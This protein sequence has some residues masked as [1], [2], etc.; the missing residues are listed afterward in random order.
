MVAKKQVAGNEGKGEDLP[1][2]PTQPGNRRLGKVLCKKP[3]KIISLLSMCID[4]G[5]QTTASIILSD[6][7]VDFDTVL[8][9]ITKRRNFLAEDFEFDKDPLLCSLTKLMSSMMKVL[10][11]D[12]RLYIRDSFWAVSTVVGRSIL[13]SFVSNLNVIAGQAKEDAR[14]KKHIRNGEMKVEKA[15]TM[16]HD[17]F[18]EIELVLME[19]E[20]GQLVLGI[21]SMCISIVSGARDAAHGGGGVTAEEQ[22]WSEQ[23]LGGGSNETAGADDEADSVSKS[24]YGGAVQRRAAVSSILVSVESIHRAGNFVGGGRGFGRISGKASKDLIDS[25]ADLLRTICPL[26][27]CLSKA[28]E[29]LDDV[30]K[31]ISHEEAA[32]DVSSALET[33]TSKD[34][35]RFFSAAIAQN[36]KIKNAVNARRFTFAQVLEEAEVST[37]PEHW[38][39]GHKAYKRMFPSAVSVT[40]TGIVNRMIKYVNAHNFDQDETHCIRVFSALTAHLLR[41]RANPDGTLMSITE[42]LEG[43]AMQEKLGAFRQRQNHL[44][45]HGVTQAALF[46]IATHDSGSPG[47]LAD[48]ASTFLMEVVRY[49]N[50]KTQGTV[51]I[52]LK[53]MDKDAKIL[54]YLRTRLDTGRSAIIERQA[55]GGGIGFQMMEEAMHTE[56]S[57]LGRAL[58]LVT[59]F[60][61]GHNESFQNILR[62]QPER[63]F[64]ID[65]ISH[66]VDI[67]VLQAASNHALARMENADVDLLTQIMEV[68]VEAMQGPCTEN[69]K[70]ITSH[71]VFFTSVDRVMHTSFHE[72]VF[73]ST[74]LR[75]NAVA[76]DLLSACL[77]GRTDTLVH[78]IIALEMLPL[79]LDNARH[80]LCSL[81]SAAAQGALPK[82]DIE[83]TMQLSIRG[84][85][86]LT[87]VYDKM[88][89]V[90][91]FFDQLQ[92]LTAERRKAHGLDAMDTEVGQVE[93]NWNGVIEVVSFRNPPECVFLSAATKSKFEDKVDLRTAG[94]RTAA[95]F[96]K[97]PAFIFEMR[98]AAFMCENYSSYKQLYP[99]VGQFRWFVYALTVLLNFNL[100]MSTVGNGKGDKF[101]EQ[102][103][104]G[105]NRLSNVFTAALCLGVLIG[106]C[107]LFCFFSASEIPLLVHKTES[108]T[109]KLIANP[110]FKKSMFRD[111][112]AFSAWIVV[113]VGVAFFVFMHFQNYNPSNYDDQ[114]R[115]SALNLELYQ[116]LVLFCVIFYYLRCFRNWIVVPDT[117]ATRCYVILY[118]LLFRR[119]FFPRYT[120]LIVFTI[121]GYSRPEYCTL[122]LL[123]ILDLE[124]LLGAVVRCVIIPGRSLLLVIYLVLCSG[125]VYALFGI[126]NFENADWGDC[127]SAVSCFWLIVYKHVIKPHE[128]MG[129]AD[130]SHRGLNGE[131]IF[132]I[133]MLFDL[134]WFIWLFLL[135]KLLTALLY[136]TFTKLNA[137][138]KQRK[139]VL[140]NTGFVSGLG[141][142]PYG[143]LGIM[144]PS[145]DE[146]VKG[147]Q[148]HWNYVN[149]LLHLIKKNS[150]DYNGCESFVQKNLDEGSLEWLPIKTSFAIQE[151]AKSGHDTS[152]LK[153]GGVLT[154]ESTLAAFRKDFVLLNK[155]VKK[156]NRGM[157]KMVDAAIGKADKEKE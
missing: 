128:I 155:D 113:V 131:P 48:V 45:S 140:G 35:F 5:N 1:V 141:R 62:N 21:I 112:S 36:E 149:F 39:G 9:A 88:R 127:H 31:I 34:M 133:R 49:G 91:S 134:S 146:L 68:L 58:S 114:K 24:V 52:Y 125:A 111:S 4:H 27:A 98:Q 104:I 147:K 69:Q 8:F 18:Q 23:L 44:N 70:S 6:M 22:K 122:L 60:M 67:F 26:S 152:A 126:R 28:D 96:D 50:V 103:D 109:K 157:S 154:I 10:I 107:I 144:N 89:A 142:G 71:A 82:E 15:E 156:L 108:R 46:A 37:D 136:G 73:A 93:V 2:A 99:Y 135:F 57:H 51:L 83:E 94:K 143:D 42:D 124:F 80:Q 123:E 119:S 32:V 85:V 101:R 29:R 64:S 75:A 20:Q 117:R 41:A 132:M 12:P 77:E 78:E 11:V 87:T 110:L 61:D 17:T 90:P 86:S 43:D 53:E 105:E 76:V 33:N 138:S 145:F 116:T 81:Y 25:C 95:L 120:L 19:Q 148:N 92:D 102:R 106:Y 13:A 56:Y 100:L 7:K 59:L 118:D 66:A 55:S 130:I 3:E 38:P 63:D 153:N 74:C 115:R 151:L 139:D 121:A 84:L 30:V 79:G 97:T 129:F 65:L 40:W 137:S 14:V 16:A 54:T 47:S 150:A 72:R